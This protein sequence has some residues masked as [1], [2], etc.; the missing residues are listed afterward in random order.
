MLFRVT[1]F[2]LLLSI[3][4]STRAAEPR[5][6]PR[7]SGS[8]VVNQW[9][10]SMSLR[11]KAAQLISMA[12]YGEAPSKRSDDYKKF[13]HWVRDLRIGGLIVNNRITGGQV[14]NAEPHAMALFL[15][16]MQRQ[17]RV[18]LIVGG[19]FERGASMR[20][21]NTV[22]FPYPM[23]YG[24]AN[25]LAATRALGAETAREARALGVQWVYGPDADVNNN[26]EN[27]IINI[28]SFGEDPRA[29]AAQVG[30]FID[31]AHAETSARVL[32][33]AKHFPGHGDTSTDSHLGLPRVDADRARMSQVEL[34]PFRAAI[35]H[36]VDSIMT[37]HLAVP[38]YEPESIPATVS[39]NILTGLLRVDLGFRGIIITDAM[40]MQGLTKLFPPGEASVRALEAGVDMLL[41][42]TDPEQAIQDIVAAVK[43]GRLSRKRIDQSVSKLLS[44]K[45]RV[46]LPRR[47]IV[48]LDEISDVLDNEDAQAQ[49]QRV[50]DEALT[51]VRNDNGA[52]PFRNPENSC[53]VALSEGRFSQE[54]RRLGDEVRK[55]NPKIRFF[56]LDPSAD[57]AVAAD[58]VQKTASC[59]SVAVAAFV[60][61]GAYHGNVALP[62]VFPDLVTQ[63]TSAQAPVTLIALGN[64]YLLKAFPKVAAYIAAF[65]PVPVSEA[66]TVKALFGEIPITGHMPVSIPGFAKIGDGIQ[67]GAAHSLSSK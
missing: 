67:L 42:P 60:T 18:P 52:F 5:R 17:A 39:K 12:C 15:N 57:E 16:Q 44:A 9:M 53:V 13:Q 38:A 46:G 30:A 55:R 24:A 66:A 43:N 54:G 47:R 59:E 10:K 11:D 36:G 26:P 41:M 56:L 23:A 8:A 49:A 63:L 62:G 50:A 21:A 58:V 1:S 32:I 28:R 61:V 37:A 51:L 20:V 6:Q 25:D 40:D 14:R 34:V 64:P 48:D 45:A 33:T 19:D 3:S 2:A 65:S 35:E 4:L 22:K 27:P 31:G 29:V 7:D